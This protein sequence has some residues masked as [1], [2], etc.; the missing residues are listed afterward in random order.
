MNAAATVIS[1]GDSEGHGHPQ[2]AVVAG[3]AVSGHAS[4]NQAGDLLTPLV[5][6]TE[7]ARSVR[8]GR[9]TELEI[10]GTQSQPG[11]TIGAA[12]LART[13][14][15]FR[16]QRP[17]AISP[18][19]DTRALRDT[20]IVPGIVYGLVNVRTDGETILCATRDEAKHD[21]DIATFPARF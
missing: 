17:G 16:E 12:E 10:A 13:T 3:S 14:A 8:L 21:W 5:Y 18:T 7:I 2:A 4:F 15:T 1:S 9:V 20:Y 6:S 19:T 11:Q